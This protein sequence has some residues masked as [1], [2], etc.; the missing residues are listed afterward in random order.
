MVYSKYKSK[1]NKNQKSRKSRKFK[2]GSQVAEN[3]HV[4]I[5]AIDIEDNL[6][7]SILPKI[8]RVIEN[9]KEVEYESN[10]IQITEIKILATK[11]MKI[12]GI[13]LAD[14][15]PFDVIVKSILRDETYYHSETEEYNHTNCIFLGGIYVTITDIEKAR[16]IE[17]Q[18]IENEREAQRIENERKSQR[19][20]DERLKGEKEALRKEAEKE[21]QRI[22]A[23]KEALRKEA[24]KEAQRI[25]AEKKAQRI[26]AQRIEA[27]RIEA[28]RIEADRLKAEKED[29]KA[30]LEGRIPDRIEGY[31][32]RRK[33]AKQYLGWN[34]NPHVSNQGQY[35]YSKSEPKSEPQI[36]PEPKSELSG[37]SGDPWYRR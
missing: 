5:Y 28:Q 37:F 25:E 36:K 13:K 9:E 26:E 19:I 8:F 6:P 10:K 29:E 27:Q 17:A 7:M 4:L 15:M 12:S 3:L 16:E 33:W 34:S 23:E 18:R 1:K 2:G 30:I 11:E 24:E 20:E 22:E 21:A 32:N 35:S 14:K 31:E